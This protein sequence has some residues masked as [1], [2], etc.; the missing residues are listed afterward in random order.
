[1]IK[2]DKPRTPPTQEAL[3]VT[4]RAVLTA[5]QRAAFFALPTDRAELA[6]RYTLSE[7]DLAIIGR[8]RR[9]RNRLGLALQLCVLR[10]PG[11]LLRPGELIPHPTLAFVA[12]QIGAGPDTLVDYAS[13]ENTRYE[14]SSALQA[15]FGFR[16]FTGSARAEVEAWLG[17]R[18]IE[19]LS[20]GPSSLY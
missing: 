15:D 16:P 18:A 10:Y 2:W 17:T 8:R 6:R 20:P 4:R 12:E 3:P 9:P 11:R 1:V 14:H 5:A 13:R 7:A 19:A